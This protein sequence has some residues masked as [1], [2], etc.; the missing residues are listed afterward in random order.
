MSLSAATCFSG[1]GAPEVAMP[2]WNW[3]WCAEIEKFPS[4]VMAARHPQS[5]NLGDV[6]ADDFMQRASSFGRLDVL[7]GGPPCQAFS[8]AGL[9]KSM[10][11][12]RGN[13]SLRFVKI[14]HAIRPRNLLVENV[15]G[16]LNTP[17]NAFGCF[18]GAILGCD[19][20]LHSP[21]DGAWPRTGMASGPLGRL[22][23]TT[24]D[25]QY[26]GVAQRRRRVFVV[27]DFGGGADPA[28]VLFEPQ[29]MCRDNPPRR[30]TG[31]RVAGTIARSSFSGGAGGRPEGAAVGHFQFVECGAQVSGPLHTKVPGQASIVDNTDK[32]ISCEDVW[33]AEVAATL[34]AA[35][36]SKRGTD[37]QHVLGGGSYFVP[38]VLGTLT[39]RMMKS[40]GAR[41]VE[42]G[43]LLAVDPCDAQPIAFEANMSLQSPEVSGVN[44]TLTRRTH[45]SIAFGV[46]YENNA[47]KADEAIGPLLSGSKSGGGRPL[48]ALAYRTTGNNGAYETGDRTDALTTSTD[49]NSHV[50]AL[51]DCS[52][53][54]KSQGGPGWNKNVAYTLDTSALQ[55]V[56]TG[57]Q[58]RR[59]T[60]VECE[61]L[62]GFPDNFT[63]IEYRGKPAADG[64]RYKALGNSWAVPVGRWIMER[65]EKFM[66]EETA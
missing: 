37:N 47:C 36:G 17:D 56:A 39:A 64:P 2:H 41:D 16:W 21:A 26:F 3:R 31:Q 35:F 49:P 9:R 33:P 8:V 19:D 65:I 42:E 45:A 60:P 10:D 63:N 11:D 59:L 30:E 14:A 54:D 5:V 34:N 23:W 48:P 32:L 66:P 24:L 18:L 15:P 4:A 27:V 20:A 51:Q 25:A 28:S 62:Q 50:I 12:D 43:A 58:V 6:T 38:D 57:W 46:D 44:P 22:C 53:R 40:L 52:G 61:R 7:A 13:L 1:I 29:S 55:G